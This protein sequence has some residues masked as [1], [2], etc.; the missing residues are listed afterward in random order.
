M[1]P[2]RVSAIT[3][4]LPLLSGADADVRDLRGIVSDLENGDIRQALT[5]PRLR[6]MDV[7]DDREVMALVNLMTGEEETAWLAELL[8]AQRARPVP[9]HAL[10][11]GAAR[12][13]TLGGLMHKAGIRAQPQDLLSCLRLVLDY[14]GEDEVSIPVPSALLDGVATCLE[15]GQ[16]LESGTRLP[17]SGPEGWPLGGVEILVGQLVVVLPTSA[18][19]F[20]A[21]P[22]FLPTEGDH[23]PLLALALS[24][25]ESDSR[26]NP[27]DGEEAGD[28][29]AEEA[30]NVSAMKNLV[31][32]NIQSTSLVLGFL[33]NA[34]FTSIPGL[35]ES[36]AVRT[37]NPRIIEVIATDRTL[38]TGFAN[39]G[40]ALA[41]L[42]SPVNVP[43]K[44]LRRFIHVKF[45]SKVDL[46]RM[47]QDKA[48]VR[49]EVLREIKKYLET[50]A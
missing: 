3:R 9:V 43:P 6:A 29:K 33:R 7:M 23:D 36:V 31:L 44:T 11:Y 40:V 10:A 48:G 25:S 34:K 4:L 38:H 12:L 20:P 28:E 26:S 2:Y 22:H 41:C 45:V 8:G 47:A 14:N 16:T 17:D 24:G 42:R 21:W 39:R 19:D 50:L 46:K 13:M 1:D 5:V 37:R 18:A 15:K 49:K 35:V 30:L 27:D 32:T